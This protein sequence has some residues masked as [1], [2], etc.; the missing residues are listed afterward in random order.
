MAAHTFDLQNAKTLTVTPAEDHDLVEIRGAEGQ[1]ELQQG[2][3][4]RQGLP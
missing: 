4:P 3:D 2:R 1:L